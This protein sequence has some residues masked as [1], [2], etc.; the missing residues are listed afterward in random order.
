M[1]FSDKTATSKNTVAGIKN[2]NFEPNYF[3]IIFT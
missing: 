2:N 1:K 3:T